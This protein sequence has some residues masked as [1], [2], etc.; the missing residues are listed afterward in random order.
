MFKLMFT[1][2]IIETNGN[3][4]EKFCKIVY[5]NDEMKTNISLDSNLQISINDTQKTRFFC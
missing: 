3:T 5:S 4:G 1:K 2:K